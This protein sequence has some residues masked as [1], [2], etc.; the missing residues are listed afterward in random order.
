MKTQ[1]NRFILF[2]IQKQVETLAK[3]T[4]LENGQ[5]RYPTFGGGR[6]WILIHSSKWRNIRTNWL[7]D[8]EIEEKV[9]KI[10]D[11]ENV[12]K[13]YLNTKQLWILKKVASTIFWSLLKKERPMLKKTSDAGEMAKNDG[14]IEERVKKIM[15]SETINWSLVSEG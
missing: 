1:K 6:T 8:K 15:D 13:I 2:F 9:K 5:I 3:R 11:S 14:V 12:Y 10:M 7:C 4:S